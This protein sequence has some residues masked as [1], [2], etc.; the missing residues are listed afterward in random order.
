[1]RPRV[2]SDE[3][4]VFAS[5]YGTDTYDVGT[6][7]HVAWVT[8]ISAD[9]SIRA[10]ERVEMVETCCPEKWAIGPDGVAYGIV[11]PSAH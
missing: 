5:Q 3:L 6:V 2:I 10:G 7:S 9:G 4:T 8:I 11:V 1:M